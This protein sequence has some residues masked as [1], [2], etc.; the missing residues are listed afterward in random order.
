MSRKGKRWVLVKYFDGFPKESDVRLEEFDI[1]ALQDGEVLVEAEFLTVDPY[2]RPY[3]RRMAEGM[4]MIGEQVA[5]VTE[6]RNDKFPLGT[7][8]KGFLGWSTHTVDDGK[9]LN[10]MPT[11]P[12]NMPRSYALGTIGLPGMSAYVGFLDICTPKEG[13]IVLVSG[14]AGAVGSV[15][16]QI[17][18][19]KGCRVI[20]SAGSDEKVKYLKEI[21]FDEAFNYKKTMDLDAKLKELAPD[22][23]DIYFDNVGGEFATTATMNLRQ[24]GRISC[25]GSISTYNTD[26]PVKTTAVFGRMVFLE[27]K[28]QGFLIPT[29]AGRYPAGLADLTK[30]VTEGKIKV[31]EHVTEGF[32]N[33]F[34]AFTELFTGANTGKAIIKV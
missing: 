21:G 4:V 30:W 29:Y 9:R 34:T 7:W 18:K 16:G 12:P 25:C 23:I 3:N 26:N 33:M 31:R 17:A 24:Y 1:P 28:M 2:M 15:V 11:L 32:E 27:L 20:G 8:V 22:G 19:I 6:S 14:A 10:E 5:K 13:E